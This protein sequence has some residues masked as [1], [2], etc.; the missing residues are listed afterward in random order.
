MPPLQQHAATAHT[1]LG[2]WSPQVLLQHGAHRLTLVSCGA[3]LLLCRLLR[4]LTTWAPACRY[5]IRYQRHAFDC[6][7][8]NLFNLALDLS[9]RHFV[10]AA[11]VVAVLGFVS[12]A[13]R[14]F[15]GKA[16]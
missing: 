5:K 13:D 6:V 14:P 1:Y 4:A 7:T 15:R 16:E 12:H 2:L 10:L 8:L 3:E 11:W 9:D